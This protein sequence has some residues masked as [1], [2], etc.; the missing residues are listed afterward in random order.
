MLSVSRRSP[1]LTLD[2][3]NAA[4]ARNVTSAR[5]YSVVLRSHDLSARS[6]TLGRRP[7]AQARSISLWGSAATQ[8]APAA[9]APPPVDEPT[10]AAAEV[11]PTWTDAPIP[12]ASTPSPFAPETLETLAD[13]SLLSPES[14][15]ALAAH[16][17]PLQPGDLSA[18]GLISYTPA[19]LIRWS[20]EVLHTTTH[21]PW[22]WTI[23]G[24]T[25][26][27]RV[28]LLPLT[29][30][31][32][33]NAARMVRHGPA[34][35][36]ASEEFKA[37][38]AATSDPGA[39]AAAMGKMM[40]VY[41]AAGVNPR[42][43]MLAPIVQLPVVLGLFIGIK[44]MCEHPVAQLAASGVDLASVPA[45]ASFSG[46]LPNL[47]DLTMLTSAADPY[48]LLSLLSV[49][50]MNAQ[51]GLAVRETDPAKPVAP[52]IFN[53]LRVIAPFGAICMTWLPVGVMVSM[54]TTV[55]STL[56]TSA[57]MQLPRVRGAFGIPALGADAPRL[58]KLMESRK[59]LGE[60]LREGRAK[61]IEEA[62]RREAEK[63]GKGKGGKL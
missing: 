11:E 60:Y 25:L 19:G 58:P 18:L 22:F 53:A 40:G 44:G 6:L 8:P 7:Q 62:M 37:A 51:M 38:V 43:M 27:W 3:L 55:V 4:R 31:A 15:T 17:P 30:R 34:L 49:L 33:R 61:A 47:S 52:H 16:L 26:A 35:Q 13:P 50:L 39:R 54:L 59:M 56:A 14:L 46:I 63:E 45:L 41:A 24:G 23:C 1:P 9:P 2:A 48:L 21:L 57:V 36:Q 20:L 29:V 42:T 32:M 12:G 10:L 28:L 5:S